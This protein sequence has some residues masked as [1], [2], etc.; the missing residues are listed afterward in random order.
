MYVYSIIGSYINESKRRQETQT[1]VCVLLIQIFLLIY[2][3]RTHSK[4]HVFCYP[5]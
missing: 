5:I 1:C 2:I 3:Y 4:I